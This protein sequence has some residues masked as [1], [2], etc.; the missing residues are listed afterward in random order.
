LT[1][2]LTELGE[3]D[4][5]LDIPLSFRRRTLLCLLIYLSILTISIRPLQTRRTT[6]STV[7]VPA[8]HPPLRRRQDESYDDD[9]PDDEPHDGYGNGD[10]G[11]GNANDGHGDDAGGGTRNA[12]NGDV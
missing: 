7:P 11:Y 4:L 6:T 12:G 5:P 10:D 9:E 2:S 3:V 1:T 8:T